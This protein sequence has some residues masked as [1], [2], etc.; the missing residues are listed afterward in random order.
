MRHSDNL[1]SFK[2]PPDTQA[3]VHGASPTDHW[4]VPGSIDMNVGLTFRLLNDLSG[5]PE[6]ARLVYLSTLLIRGDCPTPFSEQDLDCGQSFLTPYAQAK[7][8][9]ESTIQTTYVKSVD[10]VILR[11]GSV[12]WSRAGGELPRRDWFCQSVRQWRKGT[13]PLIPLSAEQRFYPI[14][15]D[16]LCAL[17][18]SSIVAPDVPGVVHVPGDAGPTL[19]SVFD[20]L[21]RETGHTKP[22]FCASNSDEWI[23]FLDSLQPSVLK[24]RIAALFPVPPEGAKLASV[25]SERSRE[26][27]KRTGLKRAPL[28]EE[29]W[30]HTLATS[31]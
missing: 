20:V 5:H 4:D 9:A 14:P 19:G 6:P 2:I 11:L 23:G 1:A 7:F 31:D 22:R 18:W 15:V 10:T 29:Y 16:E 30:T 12:L 17:I 21:A 8:L 3:V 27:I 28:P 13:L 26:W 24:R 25:N